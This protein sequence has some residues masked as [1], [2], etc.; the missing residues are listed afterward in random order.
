M[1]NFINITDKEFQE[2]KF[3]ITKYTFVHFLAGI[4]WYLIFRNFLNTQLNFSLLLLVHVL[5]EL[6]ENSKF[7]IKYF[8]QSGWK[9]YTGDSFMNSFFDTIFS[10]SGFV[11][12]EYIFRIVN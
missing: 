12:A 10:M 6:I 5:F 1:W 11:L 7:G 4:V 8:R 9:Y 2:H 3:Y